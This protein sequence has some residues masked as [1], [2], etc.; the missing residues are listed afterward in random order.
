MDY[1]ENLIADQV[2]YMHIVRPVE[3]YFFTHQDN[4]HKSLSSVTAV[5]TSTRSITTW[6]NKIKLLV[7]LNFV[8][9]LSGAIN[10]K[11]QKRI[12]SKTQLLNYQGLEKKISIDLQIKSDLN[13]IK[14]PWVLSQ[15]TATSDLETLL[16]K[17]NLW[18]NANLF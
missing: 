10:H 14:L 8:C 15:I 1:G 17:K 5:A 4:T 12:Y 11:Y 9:F 16:M 3:I 6:R 2:W 13:W 18:K 7:K